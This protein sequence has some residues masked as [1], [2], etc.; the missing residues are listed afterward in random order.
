MMIPFSIIVLI[1]VFFLFAIRKIGR[2]KFEMWQIMLLGAIVVLLTRQISIKAAIRSINFEVIIFLFGMFVIGRALEES[3]ILSR[4]TFSLINVLNNFNMLLLL[5]VFS[6]GILAA[7][8]MNDTVAVIGIPIVLLISSKYKIN[9]KPLLLALAFSVTVGS[10]MSPI[11]NPQNL[12]IALEG[13]V[14]NPF[15]TFFKYLFMPTVINLVIVYLLIRTLY[16]KEKPIKIIQEENF[17]FE[18]KTLARISK[19]SL[20]I[21]I[22]LILL[23][24]ILAYLKVGFELNLIYISILS[25]FPIVLLSK[26]RIEIVR[27]IDW[28]T[29]IFFISMFILM[30]SVWDSGYFQKWLVENKQITSLTSIFLI[31]IILSQFLSNVPLVALYL[32]ILQSANISTKGLM[33]LAAASTIAGNFI[34]LGAASN[35]IIIQSVEKRSKET[36]TFLEF[37]RI[38]IPL[39]IIN[40]VIY[41]LF[42]RIIP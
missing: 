28:H 14:I 27:N 36:I 21:L 19:L 9:T 10:A 17:N 26:K 3:G 1:C 16:K 40:A 22:T 32:P 11:G 38:G 23:K 8:L 35:I 39:T 6:F 24:V 4:I 20:S 42:L 13:E 5:L 29:L 15:F 30:A 34:I 41:W 33:A 31:S 2:F 18:D 25:M 37:S 12:L 7:F